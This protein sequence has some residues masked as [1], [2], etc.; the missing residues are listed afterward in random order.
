MKIKAIFNW[1]GGKDS[2]FALY[3]ILNGN[4]YSVE[5][6][7]TTISLKYKRISMHGVR[8][9]LLNLQT[10]R[11]GIPLEKVWL[12]D[13]A[14]MEVYEQTISEKMLELKDRQITHAIFGDIFLEGLKKWREDQ[15]A[16]LGFTG[17]F[18]LW[19][20]NSQRLVNEFI[21]LGFKTIV[22]SVDTKYLD[23]SFVGQVID[24]EFLKRLPSYVDPCGENGEFHTFVFDGPI[25]KSPVPFTVGEKLYKEYPSHNGKPGE[26]NGFWY[27]DLIPV[28]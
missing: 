2:A 8:E 9:T 12:P 24:H 19:I 21:D 28:I 22:V 5:G 15:L 6:L 26:Q 23:E 18:P 3:K 16:K 27:C 11:I 25:F 20:K 13:V 7:L 10:E 4:K 1:S 17:V 14:S